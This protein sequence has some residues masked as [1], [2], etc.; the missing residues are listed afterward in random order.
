MRKLCSDARSDLDSL[1]FMKDRIAPPII[2]ELWFR[3][4]LLSCSDQNEN[5]KANGLAER[6]GSCEGT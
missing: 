3:A 2:R 1:L 6:L 4:M 5:V